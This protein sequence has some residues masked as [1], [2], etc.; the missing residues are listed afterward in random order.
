[1]S[2]HALAMIAGVVERPKQRGPQASGSTKNASEPAQ[3]APPDNDVP[4]STTAAVSWQEED[5]D[6]EGPSQQPEQ[7]QGAS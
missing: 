1:M 3:N 7:P 5:F 2:E 4:A 6:S